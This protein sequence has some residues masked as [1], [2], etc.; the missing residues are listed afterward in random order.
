[1]KRCNAL[2]ILCLYSAALFA[3]STNATISGGVADPSGKLV[4]GA[5]VSIENDATGVISK[6]RSRDSRQSLRPMWSSMSR[7]PF[8]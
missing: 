8:R 2:L 1:M 3:Q 5:D 7:V 6:S 4:P